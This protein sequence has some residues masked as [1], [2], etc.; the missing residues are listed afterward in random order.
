MLNCAPRTLQHRPRVSERRQ[1]LWPLLTLALAANLAGAGVWVATADARTSLTDT[2]QT[3]DWQAPPDLTPAAHQRPHKTPAQEALEALSANLTSNHPELTTST[4]RNIHLP[5]CARDDQAATVTLTNSTK[6]WW[7]ADLIALTAGAGREQVA[8]WQQT[9]PEC[10]PARTTHP[11]A[12]PSGA[13]GFQTRT[14]TSRT[15]LVQTI[16]NRGDVAV[17]LT[18]PNTHTAAQAATLL[19]NALQTAI[20]PVC[21]D[22]SPTLADARRNPTH[23][24]YAPYQATATLPVPAPATPSAPIDNATAD[25]W[26]LPTP[27]PQ[28]HLAPLSSNQ[29][30]WTT[31][32]TPPA[33]LTPEEAAK[34]PAPELINPDDFTLINE[35]PTT[36]PSPP[37]RPTL[38]TEHTY[39]YPTKD[40][41][42][43]GCGWS[44]TATAPPNVDENTLTRTAQAAHTAAT[45]DINT[46]RAQHHVADRAW[47]RAYTTWTTHRAQAQAGLTYR[48]AY[49]DA[50][51]DWAAAEE[52]YEASVDAFVAAQQAALVPP[53]PELPDA[54]TSP[55][56]VE[57]D[58]VPDMPP[59]TDVPSL[60]PEPTPAPTP[61]T[62]EPS[63]SP[64]QGMTP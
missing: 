6:N 10:S 27:Q 29:P 38:P 39:T 28:D 49:Q 44:F 62:P 61:S 20:A 11:S 17:I 54:P 31:N 32:A 3:P 45:R 55:P 48:T 23:D 14:W 12:L 15:N 33:P 37:T 18:S 4:G 59:G 64:S 43:P 46:L 8:T 51:A 1:R 13:E 21:H 52:V 26:P 53:E 58:P 60:E 9:L 63:A 19:D 5:T 22:L 47:Q 57:P 2:A 16:W 41:A 35:A 56:P 42:G 25:P 24:Q 34:D 7:T 40:T 36:L 50:L 30:A